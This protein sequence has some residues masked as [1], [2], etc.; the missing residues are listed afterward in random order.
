MNIQDIIIAYEQKRI[1]DNIIYSYIFSL[2]KFKILAVYTG[3]NNVGTDVRAVFLLNLQTKLAEMMDGSQDYFFLTP[4]AA[5]EWRKNNI[6][7]THIPRMQNELKK[8]DN[9]LKQL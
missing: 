9:E 8:I 3:R 1:P 6:L 7:K 5:M 4:K 2:N